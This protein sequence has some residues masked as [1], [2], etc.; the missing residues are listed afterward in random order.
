[1][2]LIAFKLTIAAQPPPPPPS[3]SP[4]KS[5]RPPPPVG[6]P[7]THP[8]YLSLPPSS[9]TATTKSSL[10]R[11]FI[12]IARPPHCHRAPVRLELIFSALPSLFCALTNELPCFRLAKSQTPASTPPCPS[13]LPSA[14][15]SV[16]S[17]LHDPAVVHCPWTRSTGFP[18][19]K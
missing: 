16:H 18:L 13:V 17:G 5:R 12:I 3:S 2:A 10:H 19:L 6:S 4:Y 9:S 14:L 11:C 15:P 7:H 8:L 1:M